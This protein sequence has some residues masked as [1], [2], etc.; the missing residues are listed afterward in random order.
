MN[1]MLRNPLCMPLGAERRTHRGREG[2]CHFSFAVAA[3][4]WAAV[5]AC[6]FLALWN[7]ETTAGA[8]GS[9]PSDWPASAALV[10]DPGRANLVLVA[11][12]HCPC[13]RATIDEL[14][15]LITQCPD[16]V[17][18]HVLF[19]KPAGFPKAWEQTDLWY[20]TA[21]LRGVRVICDEEGREA[22]RFGAGTSGHALL[23]GQN[24][25]LLFSG[26]ITNARGHAGDSVGRSTIQQ[27]LT[28]TTAGPT[29]TP[30]YGCPLRN[31]CPAQA[32]AGERCKM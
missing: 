24:G 9:P 17:A 16:A 27:L 25:K 32:H 26:G 23:Y 15:R 28:G 30:V 29:D 12:P 6:G 7:Y 1:E 19:F 20:R 4:L 10:A 5:V 2:R 13:T 11:H 22:L 14:E 31:G 21:A 3:A 8:S 18:V